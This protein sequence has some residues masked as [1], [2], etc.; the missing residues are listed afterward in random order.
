M[1]KV[2][3]DEMNPSQKQVIV[4]LNDAMKNLF[5]VFV[6]VDERNI[7]ISDALDIIGVEIPLLLKPAINQLSGKLKQMRKEA[8]E[9][10]V[11]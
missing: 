5:D 10:T 3:F 2:N 8:P 6:K 4:E 1:A 11:T 9:E 7:P